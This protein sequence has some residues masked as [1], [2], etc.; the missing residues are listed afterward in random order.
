[1]KVI[2]FNYNLPSEADE[3]YKKL[4]A[5]GFQQRDLFLVDNGSDKAPKSIHTNLQLPYN[6]RFTGQAFMALTYLL[7]FP[8]DKTEHY[9]LI[10]TSA[11]LYDDI[12]YHEESIK[13]CDYID[14][15]NCGF[16]CASM[17]GGMTEINANEQL[18]SRL[19]SD[20]TP[21]FNYQP[22][23]MVIGKGLLKACQAESAAYFNLSLIRGWGID[24]ELHYLAVKNKMLPHVS[25]NLHIEWVTN[26]T[27]RK[28]MADESRSDYHT[29]AE[30]EM[31]KVLSKK[32]GIDWSTKFKNEYLLLSNEGETTKKI[33]LITFGKYFLTKLNLYSLIRKIM[34]KYN[35]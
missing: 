20:Y 21:I 16:V 10:T 22:I 6:V 1:M 12:N 9:I 7:S 3:I 15:N 17:T 35:D 27:H 4:I 14:R 8:I 31:I 26:Q 13:A 24:R 5:D 30:I 32:Y 11:K 19:T 34:V 18:Y 28:N 2:I 25:R 29:Q 33:K 23:F